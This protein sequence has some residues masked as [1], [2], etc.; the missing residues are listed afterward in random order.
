MSLAANEA[1]D[2]GLKGDSAE[3]CASPLRAGVKQP[4]FTHGCEASLCHRAASRL[5][6]GFT[7]IELLVVIAI[8]AILAALLLPAL[9]GARLK[10]QQIACLSNLKQL[11]QVAFAYQED[12]G[13][14][15]FPYDSNGEL[16]WA[17]P[18][19]NAPPSTAASD[20]RFCP[21]ARQPDP[22]QP[23]LPR[24]TGIYPGT[25]ANCWVQGFQAGVPKNS[26]DGG[27]YALN[28]WLYADPSPTGASPER[29]ASFSS[30]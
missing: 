12:Y 19:G 23:P 20:L 16:L 15:G 7:L 5:S 9:S 4:E 11:G 2:N 8:I 29:F 17:R 1:R 22:H 14:K 28:G 26:D 3:H 10:A 30:I 18:S 6:Q 27:S 13:G 21:L 24:A 25:A